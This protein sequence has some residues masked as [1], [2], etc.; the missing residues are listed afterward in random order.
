MKPSVVLLVIPSVLF[1]AVGGFFASE[2][3]SAGKTSSSSKKM[4]PR[5]AF[6]SSSD[7][8]FD[9]EKIAQICLAAGAQNSRRPGGA[10]I[11]T[12]TGGSLTAKSGSPEVEKT[13][14]ALDNVMS[15]SLERGVWSGMAA[16][17]ARLLLR[18]L[19]PADVA[20]FETLLRTTL[21]RGDMKAQMG[22]WVPSGTK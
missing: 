3:M 16:T 17:R 13:K 12:S 14:A 7:D 4:T 15:V 2:T 10:P 9:Y 21:E 6:L 11:L 22:A 1:G 5:E 20:D 18:R 19:P 8:E